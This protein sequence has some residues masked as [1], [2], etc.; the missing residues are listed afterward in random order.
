MKLLFEPW[1]QYLLREGAIKEFGLPFSAQAKMDREIKKLEREMQ[2]EEHAS[3]WHRIKEELRQTK[4]AAALIG[5]YFAEGLSNEEKT[6]LWAQ[7]KDV[8]K[9]TTLAAVFA[10]PG[11]A[12][13]LPLVLKW[14][15]GALLPSSFKGD[16]T[17]P[18][19][20][21]TGTPIAGSLPGVGFRNI[22]GRVLPDDDDEAQERE[23]IKQLSEKGAQKR[24]RLS[25]KN[26]KSGGCG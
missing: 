19:E 2:S 22:P 20:E 21:T 1:R 26:K 25:F 13:L 18:I 24:I 17:P 7:I 14:T 8:A 12:V 10:A 11:G 23:Q 5:K 16:E 15:K 4:E 3:A 9:G 6:I